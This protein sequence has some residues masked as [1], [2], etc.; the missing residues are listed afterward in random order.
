MTLSR[1]S[2]ARAGVL[3][4]AALALAAGGESTSPLPVSDAQLES[5]GESIAAEIESGV[6]QLTADD[7]MTTTGGAPT[8]SRIPAGSG[9]TLSRAFSPSFSRSATAAATDV[10]CGVPSQDPPTDTDGDQ[11]PDNFSITFSLPACH[12]ESQGS[13][14]DITGK[15]LVSD[16]FPTTPGLALNFG[17]DNFRI[18][19]S[20]TEGSGAI[21]RNG[22][23]SVAATATSLSQTTNWSDAVE[24]TGIPKITVGSNWTASFVA[25]QGQTLAAG[26]PLPN[27]AYQA[28]GTVDYREGNRVASFS[29]TTITP[30][31]YS[32]SCAASSMSPFSSGHVR[33]EITSSGGSG[34]VDVTY[35][36]CNMATVVLGQ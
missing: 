32:A 13:S 11:V 20:G 25:A 10:V 3:T 1:H 26:Q 19:F 31:Q 16:P 18:G 9:L 34:Y 24:F 6:R 7:V 36:G 35:S 23:G 14:I 29:V 17:L 30:L 12:S 27:G 5:M 21:S 2:I 22:S 33:V 15:L 4:L 28:N 8:F